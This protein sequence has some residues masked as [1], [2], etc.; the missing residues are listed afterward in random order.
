VT[1]LGSPNYEVISNLV[2]NS[3]SYFPNNGA[4]P[5]GT[6]TTTTEVYENDDDSVSNIAT[7]G[8]VL[9][10]VSLSGVIGM[11]M[12]YYIYLR[13]GTGSTQERLI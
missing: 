13:A 4:Y 10:V 12:I 6:A 3:A 7:S 2:I 5:E 8:L 9:S 1:G 11:S